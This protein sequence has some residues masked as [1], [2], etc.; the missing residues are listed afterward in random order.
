MQTAIFDITHLLGI[1]TGQ[2]FVDE[3]IIVPSIVPRVGALQS[4][5]VLAKDLFKDIP[6]RR[7][8]CRHQATSLRSVGWRVIALFYH[9]PLTTSTPSLAFTGAPAPTSLTLAPRGLQAS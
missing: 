2:H 6:G 1:T 7:S 8:C 4:V 9:I 5:P 3:A